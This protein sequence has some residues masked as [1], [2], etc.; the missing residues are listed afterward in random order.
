M[1]SGVADKSPQSMFLVK[2]ISL[3][4]IRPR[5]FHPALHA[6]PF[7]WL[8]VL[9]RAEGRDTKALVSSGANNH[10]TD[11]FAQRQK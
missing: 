3:T 2:R 5:S 10:H 9:S 6:S 4:T 11:P 1:I 7:D 8:T